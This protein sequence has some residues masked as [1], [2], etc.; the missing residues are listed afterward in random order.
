MK[1]HGVSQSSG[2]ERQLTIERGIAG[3]VLT[4]M[5]HAIRKECGRIIV[6]GESL[7]NAI[8]Q[9]QAGGTAIQGLPQPQGAHLILDVEVRRNEVLLTVRPGDTADIAVG[10]D[11]LQDALEGV[12][13]SS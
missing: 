7:V 10:L 12:I 4:I 11:D 9:P 8:L 3:V 2:T 1:I 6:P 13:S 5:N